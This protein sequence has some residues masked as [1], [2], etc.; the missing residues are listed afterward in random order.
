MWLSP[1][2]GTL[3]TICEVLHPFFGGLLS[4]ERSVIWSDSCGEPASWGEAEGVGLVWPGGDFGHSWQQPPSHE[5]VTERISRPS[6]KV[7]GVR[8]KDIGCKLKRGSKV[9]K[10][11]YWDGKEV[12]EQAA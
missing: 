11:F 2:L 7:P 4:Q 8:M 3:Y 6:A 1:V 10:Y 5:E 12:V 9:S